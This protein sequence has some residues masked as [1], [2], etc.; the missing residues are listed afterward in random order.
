MRQFCPEAVV[1]FAGSSE[2]YGF[3][4][5]EECPVSEKN[6]LRPLSQ[7]AISKVHGDFSMRQYFHSY[8]L[9]TVITRGFNHSGKYRTECFAE[10]SFAKQVMERKLGLTIAP[11]EVGNL[12]ARR[13]YT[14]VRDMVEAYWLAVNK[15]EYGVPY[16]IASGE[17][18]SMR[19][20][21]E[22]IMEEAG[23][24]CDIVQDPKRMRPSD[25]PL[26]IGD[27][28]KFRN[29]TGWIPIHGGIRQICRDL[30]DYW[31]VKLEKEAEILV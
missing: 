28:S 25:V 2:E 29:R 13:D 7:Y 5:P 10:S 1:H 3:V 21:L 27:S 17:A 4:L 15:C 26:L 20:V 18:V 16:V 19:E 9:K 6:E 23:I 24:D 11:I 12:E 22:M 30:I 31:K 14:H 8:K